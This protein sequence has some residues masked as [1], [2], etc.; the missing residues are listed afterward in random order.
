MACN[1]AR[2][3]MSFLWVAFLLYSTTMWPLY[4]LVC[5]G[6]GG[7]VILLF[8]SL[9]AAVSEGEQAVEGGMQIRGRLLS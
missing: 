5:S 6:A 7:D 2:L 9:H 1:Q 8:P 4:D 3:S